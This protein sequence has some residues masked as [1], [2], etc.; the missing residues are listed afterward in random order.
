MQEFKQKKG[1]RSAKW[2]PAPS[3][4]PKTTA[5]RSIDHRSAIGRQ[6]N[7]PP[8]I[9]AAL[10][11][12]LLTHCGMSGDALRFWGESSRFRRAEKLNTAEIEQWQRDLEFNE[13]QVLELHAQ[14]HELVETTRLQGRVSWKIARAY[15]QAQRF[16]M[17]NAYMNAALN[18]NL[19]K[20]QVSAIDYDQILPF[21]DQA[22]LKHSPEPD[23][24]FDAGLCYANSARQRGWEE[25]RFLA[26]VRLFQELLRRNPDSGR[27]RY[28]LGLLY[29]KA[30][31]RYRDQDK[32][33]EYLDQ[34]LARE[35]THIPGRFARANILAEQGRLDAARAEYQLFQT[36][37]LK[38]KKKGV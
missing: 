33:L 1:L 12:I 30:Q 19:P 2:S 24:I 36:S 4:G 11:A 23:L 10:L 18:Q 35:D 20:Q 26:A 17:A 25:Q 28:Q 3:R 8:G 16:E 15:M 14:I 22:L 5:S 21:L 9:L 37:L 29:G 34:L 6:R 32:A 38:I 7:L 27:A 13:K 31:N